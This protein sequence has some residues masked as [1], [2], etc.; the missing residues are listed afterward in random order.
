MILLDSGPVIAIVDRRDGQHTICVEAA[1]TISEPLI[2]TVAVLTEAL[3]IAGGR[4]GRR[5]AWPVQDAIF[6]LVIAGRVAIA[7][8]STQSLVRTRALMEKYS[9][10]PM[11]FAD[12]TLVALG[13]ERKIDRVF[14][15]DSDFRRYRLHGRRAFEVVPG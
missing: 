15:L 8:H 4:V 5:N 1:A 9:D 11:D 3:H 12:A 10:L 13:E 2:T 14:T 6:N 7:A